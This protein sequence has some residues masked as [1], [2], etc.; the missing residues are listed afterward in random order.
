M[1]LV[2]I[3]GAMQSMGENGMRKRPFKQNVLG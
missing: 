1:E 3:L 2:E